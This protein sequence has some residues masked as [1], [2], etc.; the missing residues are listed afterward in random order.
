MSSVHISPPQ[1]GPV[2]DME[3]GRPTTFKLLSEQ[4]ENSWRSSRKWC[5]P[6]VERRCTSTIPAMK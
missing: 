2:W 4:T 6:A 5:P 3:P 1:Q